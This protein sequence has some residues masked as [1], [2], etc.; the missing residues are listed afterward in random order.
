[1][2]FPERVLSRLSGILRYR[3]KDGRSRERRSTGSAAECPDI[4]LPLV[5]GDDPV[6]S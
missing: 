3:Q 5:P 4:S 6:T 1:M 2:A